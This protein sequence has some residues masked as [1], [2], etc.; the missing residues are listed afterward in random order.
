MLGIVG[1]GAALSL[2]GIPFD[3]PVAGVRVGM[4]DGAYVIN[5]SFE[6]LDRSELDLVIAGTADSV[7]MVEGAGEE[8]SG[9]S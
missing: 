8:V 4:V 9:N 5:P 7:V 1:C 3:G 6:E 2:S